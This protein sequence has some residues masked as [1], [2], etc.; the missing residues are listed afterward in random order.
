M[1]THG[2]RYTK[3]YKIWAWIKSRTNPN[4]KNCVKNYRKFGIK[5]CEE[6]KND[7]KTFYDWAIKNGYK[8]EMLPNGKNKWTINRIMTQ[9][10][11]KNKKKKEV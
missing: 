6:W 5:M 3:L 1:K 9:P 7:F 10:E 2:L 4:S 11:N 8:E